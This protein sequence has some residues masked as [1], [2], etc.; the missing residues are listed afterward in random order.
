[1]ED[2]EPTTHLRFH[3]VLLP[4]QGGSLVLGCP[5]G[6]NRVVSY[7]RSAKFHDIGSWNEPTLFGFVLKGFCS[8]ETLYVHGC[9]IPDELP[10]QILCGEFGRGITNL[11]LRRPYCS[12]ST[13]VSMILLLPDLEK[14]AVT[15]TKKPPKQPLST[16]IAPQRRSLDLLGLYLHSNEVA[17]ALIQA[18]LTSRCICLGGAISSVHRLLATSSETL[19]AL[20][21][22]GAWLSMGSQVADE[23]YKQ[24]SQ[25]PRLGHSLPWSIYHRFPFLLPYGFAFTKQSRHITS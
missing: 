23:Q 7:V 14:V 21:L 2:K 20:M 5:R 1:M 16:P 3:R 25:I 17:E 11:C 10:G 13:I 15:S 19:V 22:E 6:G 9:A 12:L 8:L 24:T 4:R 18:R